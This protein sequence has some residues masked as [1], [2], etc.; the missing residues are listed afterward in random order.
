MKRLKFAI[1][2]PGIALIA[3]IAACSDSSEPDPSPN[4]GPG[5]GPGIGTL[6]LTE[7]T[8][9]Q[10]WGE[11]IT[12]KGEGFS[13]TKSENLVK[14]V[15]VTPTSCSLNYT[16]D[17]GDLEIVSASETQLQVRI[18]FAYNSFGEPSC[19]PS[20]VDIEVTA[21]GKKGKL[22]GVKF[23]GLPY[24]GK[25]SYHYGGFGDPNYHTLGDSVLLTAGVLGLHQKESPWHDKLRL[26][27]NGEV[28][29]FK[30]RSIAKQYGPAF[31]LL[32][33][34]FSDVSCPMGIDGYDNARKATFRFYFNG[35]MKEASRELY[36]AKLKKA[37]FACHDCESTVSK[38]NDETVVWEIRGS[39]MMFQSG[40]ISP[41]SP[42]GC[43]S[44]QEFEIVP[45]AELIKF[46]I[47]T[48]ILTVDCSYSIF[49]TNHC[50]HNTPIGTVLIK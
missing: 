18:P 22:T 25:F 48:A 47:P 46:S 10:F 26:S 28:V 7:A 27:V 11:T 50:G 49:L 44:T 13:T 30:F 6:T 24:I 2:G 37:T 41:T 12:I 9:W 21:K 8:M 29:P 16:S 17:G 38:T 43:G 31:V 15:N 36:I 34:I 3:L 14:F 19:G 35:T 39:Y 23:T 1:H 5:P 45:N 33:E 42:T 40:V 20:T 32:P 4:P